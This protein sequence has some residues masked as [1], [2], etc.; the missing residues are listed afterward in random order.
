MTNVS[1]KEKSPIFIDARGPR[2]SA[3]ITTTVLAIAL[4]TESNY[5][6]DFNL[7]SFYLLCSLGLEDQSMACYIAI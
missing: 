1:L 3:A 4:I 2:C 7:P 5:L 6:I